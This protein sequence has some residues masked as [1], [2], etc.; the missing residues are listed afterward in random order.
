MPLDMPGKFVVEAIYLKLGFC[1]SALVQA[2]R[3]I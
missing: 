1:K 3:D 2:V